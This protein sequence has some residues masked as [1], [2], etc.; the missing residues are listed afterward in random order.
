MAGFV[1]VRRKCLSTILATFPLLALV[2]AAPV[3]AGGIVRT[4][5][6]GGA[7]SVP[8]WTFLVGS[9]SS[10]LRLAH[11]LYPLSGT[12]QIGIGVTLRPRDESGLRHFLTDVYDP[13]SPTYRH[14]L[15]VQQYKQR[16][17]P[18]TE[19]HNRTVGWLK[20]SGLKVDGTSSNGLLI[21]ARGSVAKIETAFHTSLSMFR[22][23]N[24]MFFANAQALRLPG[25][26]ASNVLDV[27]GLSTMA[28]QHPSRKLSART[29]QAAPSGYSPSTLQHAYGLTALASQGID[30]SGQTVG[31]ISFGDYAASNIAAF[32]QRFNLPTT[33]LSSV[34]VSD[35]NSTGALLGAKNGQDEAES[36]IERVHSVAPKAAIVVYE[37]PNTSQGGIALYNRIVSDNRVSVI[38]VSWGGVEA[39]YSQ[40]EIKSVDQSLQEGAAQ[41]QTFIGVSGD[42]GAY[43]GA[44]AIRNG[45]TTLAVDFPASDPWITTVGGTTL[46]V[47]GSTYVGESTW[48]DTSVQPAAGGGGGLSTVFPRP[49]YQSGPG[50]NNQYS[51][52][53]RQVPDVAADANPSTGYAVY[54]VDPND[55]PGWG[56]VG[57]TSMATPTWAGF[58]ALINQSMGKRMGFLN[59]AL[60]ALGQRAFTFS[61]PPFHDVTQGTNLYYPAT[62]GWDFATGWGSFDGA[63]FL[64]DLK[65]MIASSGGSIPTAGPTS[66]PLPAATPKPTPKSPTI[67]IKKM[68]LLHVVKGKQVTTNTL[69]IGERGTLVILFQSKNGGAVRAY[70][71]VVLREKGQLLQALTLKE[72]TYGGKPALVTSFHF[73]SKKRIG[74]LQAHVTLSLGVASSALDHAF[75][76]AAN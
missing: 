44:G 16:Y 35:G 31:I 14:F 50:V 38:T 68:L 17:G 76:I 34:A 46:A 45:E 42:S 25:S 55:N 63:P 54:T 71:S 15:T 74:T 27:S 43:D 8:R 4:S 51:N 26:I 28:Q 47:Q 30:G 1:S 37:A 57:G 21:S 3:S 12:R 64:T 59:P 48:S 32:D 73:T 9:V 11:R 19:D 70:G 41:G 33:N 60:Y 18:T 2:F 20:S 49:S 36:D 6:P 39:G 66:I 7:T 52:G 22:Q 40:G 61:Q 24:R 56:I 13:T 67:S 65:T 69:K 62:V 5:V 53:M 58:A 29:V 23:G 72:S 10:E 75:R